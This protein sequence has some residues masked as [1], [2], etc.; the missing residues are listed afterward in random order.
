MTT[1]DD[2]TTDWRKIAPELEPIYSDLCTRLQG[3]HVDET[4][5]Y[6]ARVF[7]QKLTAA[8][9]AAQPQAG[10][11]EPVGWQWRFKAGVWSKWINT[12]GDLDDFKRC[13]QRV[14]A[15]G[16]VETRAIYATPSPTAAG[17]TPRDAVSGAGGK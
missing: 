10:A 15:K 3:S 5:E 1:F 11:S 12:E 13:Q 17:R 4:M 7:R 14:L 9:S 16:T 2:N 6:I 8:L